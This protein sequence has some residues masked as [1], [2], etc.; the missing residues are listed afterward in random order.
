MG[1]AVLEP[2]YTKIPV[3]EYQEPKII[4]DTID[5]DEEKLIIHDKIDPTL[6]HLFSKEGCSIATVF[7]AFFWCWMLPV[8]TLVFSA[9]I[10]Y[11]S[12]IC[13]PTRVPYI[14]APIVFMLFFGT[15]D[16]ILSKISSCDNNSINAS[17][18][19]SIKLLSL[20]SALIL[21]ILIIA[22]ECDVNLNGSKIHDGLNFNNGIVMIL[23]IVTLCFYIIK[24]IIMVSTWATLKGNFIKN[25]K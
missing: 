11:P 1:D 24:E 6:S 20:T 22:N 3:N 23:L 13:D 16:I 10:N 2:I 25:N 7:I 9:C 18:V 19:T 8:C 12:Q 5:N 17:L 21:I 4:N 14:A 15:V